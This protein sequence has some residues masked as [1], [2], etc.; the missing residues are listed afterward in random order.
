M[1]AARAPNGRWLE[2]D[3]GRSCRGS[4]GRSATACV[5]SG[6]LGGSRV[7]VFWTVWRGVGTERTLARRGRRTGVSW[8]CRAECDGLRD[9]GCSRRGQPRVSPSTVWP[10]EP[11]APGHRAARAGRSVAASG[12]EPATRA[13]PKGSELLR[14][15]RG[16]YGFRPANRPKLRPGS[17]PLVLTHRILVLRLHSHS[18]SAERVPRGLLPR[19]RASAPFNGCPDRQERAPGTPRSKTRNSAFTGALE[20]AQAA[21]FGPASSAQHRPASS[22]S[23][24]T[25]AP[26]RRAASQPTST[27]SP[28]VSRN[29]RTPSTVT[30]RA[31]VL[32]FRRT[33]PSSSRPLVSSTPSGPAR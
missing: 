17:A 32:V 19:W 12:A 27:A 1:F 10:R 14:E 26:R 33:Q 31:R 6:A 21:R 9:L 18:V 2:G 7:S 15:F 28:N 22:R 30:R 8:F 4:A 13:G 5:T 16:E 11:G 25:S 23:H 3:A 29:P 24:A 20:V